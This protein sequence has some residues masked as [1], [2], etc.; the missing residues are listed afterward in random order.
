MKNQ[1]IKNEIERRISD[2][3][4][5]T[6]SRILNPKRVV[7]SSILD[8]LIMAIDSQQRK[9]KRLFLSFQEFGRDFYM[10]DLTCRVW[11][12]WQIAKAAL[13]RLQERYR[14]VLE[15]LMSV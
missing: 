5:F 14:K 4:E 1:A 7:L 8:D 10:K 13:T 11:K 15:M 2:M 12:D 9:V 6:R 3:N